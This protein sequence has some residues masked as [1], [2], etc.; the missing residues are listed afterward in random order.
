[1]IVA[2]FNAVDGGIFINLTR[3]YKLSTHDPKAVNERFAIGMRTNSKIIAVSA[4][5][6]WASA[7]FSKNG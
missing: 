2:W 6:V 7:E 3:C 4:L 5:L 1:V